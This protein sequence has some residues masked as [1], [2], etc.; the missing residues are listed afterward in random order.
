MMISEG[1]SRP[2]A[3]PLAFEGSEEG[4]RKSQYGTN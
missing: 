2:K 4:D 3:S 1:R